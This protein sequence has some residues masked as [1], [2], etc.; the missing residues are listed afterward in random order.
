MKTPPGH[1][2]VLGRILGAMGGSLVHPADAGGTTGDLG[3]FA[4]AEGARG[5]SGAVL[6]S[7]SPKEK[8]G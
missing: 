2:G 3:L 5:S 8:G 1:P 4:D 7:G 6:G